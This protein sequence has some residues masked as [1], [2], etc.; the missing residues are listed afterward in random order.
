MGIKINDLNIDGL[1]SCDV[2]TLAIF[3]TNI[4]TQL[5][6]ASYVILIK[7]FG[8]EVIKLLFHQVCPSSSI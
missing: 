7:P 3:S 4:R 5:F 6:L 2:V 8:K 1:V